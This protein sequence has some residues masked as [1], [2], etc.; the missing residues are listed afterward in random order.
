MFSIVETES[1]VEYKIKHIISTINDTAV[2][3]DGIAALSQYPCEL[4]KV[5]II[6]AEG[7]FP[8]KQVKRAIGAL[9]SPL[10]RPNC[11]YLP[12]EICDKIYNL[13]IDQTRSDTP[14]LYDKYNNRVYCIDKKYRMIKCNQSVGDN[15]TILTTNEWKFFL[16]YEIHD[17]REVS[18]AAIL[19]N[20]VSG[21]DII[22]TRHLNTYKVRYINTRVKL[23]I[24]SP[25]LGKNTTLQFGGQVFVADALCMLKFDNLKLYQLSYKSKIEIMIYLPATDYAT[26]SIKTNKYYTMKVCKSDVIEGGLYYTN[27][28]GAATYQYLITLKEALTHIL[29]Q[30]LL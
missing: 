19:D 6:I 10:Q 3:V 22:T 26:V 16:V 20:R 8:L 1:Y 30:L 24:D 12:E 25:L 28:A 9:R 7:I 17:S 4:T 5:D 21:V 13:Y 2:S 23:T 11:F 14:L 29:K 15:Y 27:D 18:V